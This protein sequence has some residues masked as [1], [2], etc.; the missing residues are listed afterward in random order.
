MSQQTDGYEGTARYSEIIGQT[1]AAYGCEINENLLKQVVQKRVAKEPNLIDYAGRIA[2]DSEGYFIGSTAAFILRWTTGGKSWQAEVAKDQTPVDI[3]LK[4]V[5]PFSEQPDPTVVELFRKNVDQQRAVIESDLMPA[6]TALSDHDMYLLALPADWKQ[7]S[8]SF[9]GFYVDSEQQIMFSI[10]DESVKF[11]SEGADLNTDIGLVTVA[12]SL[13]SPP[14]DG[15]TSW[16]IPLKESDVQVRGSA[17][18]ISGMKTRGSVK[19]T[20]KSTP[21]GKRWICAGV[22]K[23]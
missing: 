19:G 23:T 2:L 8:T 11:S 9:K 13:G 5:A 16:I 14:C 6:T 22:P 4:D 17:F 15:Q 20:L 21:D 3:L 12:G 10:V 1:L 18:Q 7:G